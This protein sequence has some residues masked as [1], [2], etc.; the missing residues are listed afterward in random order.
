LGKVTHYWLQSNAATQQEIIGSDRLTDLALLEAP[1]FKP[2]PGYFFIC[3]IMQ[4]TEIFLA[5]RPAN[6]RVYMRKTEK[7]TVN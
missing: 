3:F 5:H 2:H 6:V 7:Y 4:H 1:H